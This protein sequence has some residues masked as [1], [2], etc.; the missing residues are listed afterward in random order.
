MAR[1]ADRTIEDLDR[2]MRI[3]RKTVRGIPFRAGSFKTTHH[4]LTLDV[5][6]LMVQLDSSRTVLDHK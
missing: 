1:T 3:L 2:A 5:A 4:N 6:L